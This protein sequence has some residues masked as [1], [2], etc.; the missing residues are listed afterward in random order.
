[1]DWTSSSRG[2]RKKSNVDETNNDATTS[3]RVVHIAHQILAI[4]DVDF[5]AESLHVTTTSLHFLLLL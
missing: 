1:M 2:E 5:K 4:H 3:Q